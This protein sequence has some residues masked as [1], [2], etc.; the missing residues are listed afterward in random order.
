MSITKT[1][2]FCVG[3]HKRSYVCPL[4]R[5]VN[6]VW[7]NIKEAIY[8]HYLDA[9]I[10]CQKTLTHTVVRIN[11]THSTKFEVAHTFKFNKVK[12]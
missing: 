1:S 2:K 3:K 11:G 7:E 4:P 8:V 6:S 12:W 10:L 9:L 5:Q